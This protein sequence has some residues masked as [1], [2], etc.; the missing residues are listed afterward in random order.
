LRKNKFEIEYETFVSN[1]SEE[2]NKL[3]T[4]AKTTNYEFHMQE[5]GEKF[6]IKNFG[7]VPKDVIEEF[8]EIYISEWNNGV[9]FFP[10]M[11]QFLKR[12]KQKY[13]L[14][15]ISNTHYP[16]LITRNLNL[17]EIAD[18][19]TLVVTS[20]EY[21]IRKP[22]KRIF[23]DTI[24]K[25]SAKPDSVVHIGDS[26]QDDYEGAIKVGLKSIL[27]DK[28]SK[29]PG[30]ITNHVNSIFAIEQYNIV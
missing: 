4:R 6:F 19:F 29:Q 24:R 16:S 21:G 10:G 7:G 12:L 20:V 14:S 3:E 13:T 17:M 11:K 30:N 8:I 26:L 1:F 25:L 18:Y 28:N 5:V 2:F 15:I 27:I 22:D 23:L 9:T